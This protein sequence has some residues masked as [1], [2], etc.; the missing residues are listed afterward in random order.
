MFSLAK[1]DFNLVE[2]QLA[3]LGDFF[4]GKSFLITGASGFFGKNLLEVLLFL[5]EKQGFGMKIYAVSRDKENFVRK[6]PAAK[7]L[8]KII[9]SNIADLKNFDGELDYVIH[10]ACDTNP[11]ILQ[12]SAQKFLH[13]NYVGCLNLLEIAA[14]KPSCKFLYLSSGAIYGSQNS[15][16]KAREEDDLSAPDLS[17]TS[18][19]YGEAKRLGEMLCT[20]FSAQF[21]LDVKVARCYS[22]VG[23]HMNFDGHYA[24]GNFIRD[25]ASK[26]DLVLESRQQVF[27]SYLY[28]VDLAIW[29]LKILFLAP[30]NSVFNVGSSIEISIQDLAYSVRDLVGSGL[31][32]VCS[33]QNSV[34]TSL[35]SRYIPSIEK[36]KHEL[37]LSEFTDLG[38]A[39]IKTYN[40]YKNESSNTCRRPGDKA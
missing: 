29:L 4:R 38:S 23:P 8:H 6:F 27:R 37:G 12:N 32:V 35:S 7:K 3:A 36:A 25:A 30:K 9:E 31:N 24:I 22:F 19:V 18:S 20:I 2:K 39:I 28:S 13:E 14:S 10:A 21:S 40:W 33:D 17:K 26:Q 11:E 5:E 1:D 16:V 15:D 34:N